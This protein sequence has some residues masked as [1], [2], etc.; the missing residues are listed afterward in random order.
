MQLRHGRDSWTANEFLTGV[1]RSLL[2]VHALKGITYALFK[3]PCIFAIVHVFAIVWVILTQFAQ[4]KGRISSTSVISVPD[5]ASLIGQYDSFILPSMR[6]KLYA[7]ILKGWYGVFDRSYITRRNCN[8]LV[9]IVRNTNL[10][11]VA[12]GIFLLP[13]S[14]RLFLK[15]SNCKEYEKL[16]TVQNG[17]KS[18]STWKKFVENI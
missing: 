2:N 8:R 15:Y 14:M 11:M 5:N 13:W 10:E 12:F 17:N 7:A 16:S 9:L 3:L 1:Y 6:T 18:V 4:S